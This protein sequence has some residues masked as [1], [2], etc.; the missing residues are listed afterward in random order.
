[1]T[2]TATPSARFASG[3]GKQAGRSPSGSAG[4]TDGAPAVKK[5]RGALLKSKKFRM[6]LVALLVVGGVGYKMFAPKHVGPAVGGDVVAMDATT[7]NLAGGHYL[8]VAVAIQLVKGKATATGFASSRAAELTIDEFS[9]RTVQALSS[10]AARKKLVAELST[11][12]KAAYEGEVYAVFLTQF[13][14]Q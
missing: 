2:V 14:T 5:S 7:L 10:N 4:E 11:K 8:K 13:V 6:V 3:S 1:M 12:I 9:D